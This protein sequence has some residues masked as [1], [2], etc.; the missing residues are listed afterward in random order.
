MYERYK[1]ETDAGQRKRLQIQLQRALISSQELGDEKIHVVTQ[2]LELV[3]NR[4]RQMDSHTHCFTDPIEER[5]PA[6]KVR[7]DGASSGVVVVGGGG[8]GG[9]GGAV[10][11][12][13]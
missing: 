11:K 7:H 3:E 9:G 4:S 10:G 2:M 6:E 8:G 12:L 13:I 1:R 5:S